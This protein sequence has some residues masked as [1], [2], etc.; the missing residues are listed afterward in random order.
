[1][2]G[3]VDHGPSPSPDHL[4]DGEPA[5]QHH[6]LQINVDDPVPDIFLDVHHAARAQDTHVVEQDV[7]SSVPLHRRFHHGLAVRGAGDV[8]LEHRC[9]PSLFPYGPQRLLGMTGLQVHE[10]YLGA[11]S[12]EEDRCGLTGPHTRPPRSGSRYYGNLTL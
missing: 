9:L 5:G 6:T 3:D 7:N 10:Q 11:L 8:G 2:E 4:R 1:M 12:G